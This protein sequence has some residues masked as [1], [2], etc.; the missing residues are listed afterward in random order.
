MRES[1]QDN[2][3]TCKSCYGNVL[4][5]IIANPYVAGIF[6][7]IPTYTLISGM[8]WVNS[9]TLIISMTSAGMSSYFTVLGVTTTFWILELA[10]IYYVMPNMLA[11]C[12]FC[13]SAIG[14]WWLVNF[15]IVMCIG[16]HYVPFSLIFYAFLGMLSPAIL[17][18][19]TGDIIRGYKDKMLEDINLV[20]SRV[21]TA[22]PP[23]YHA[24][25]DVEAGAG[26]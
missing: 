2:C 8:N 25:R 19:V 12:A 13:H 21:A 6:M 23:S 10:S 20:N 9:A 22:H 7:G 26:K 24:L 15:F 4:K 1:P 3:E 17:W 18:H 14:S 11:F 16:W 5:N